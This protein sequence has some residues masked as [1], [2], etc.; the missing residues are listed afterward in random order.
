LNFFLWTFQPR[1]RPHHDIYQRGAAPFETAMGNLLVRHC[2]RGPETPTGIEPLYL[3]RMP[4]PTK[5]RME[6]HGAYSSGAPHGSSTP[7][8]PTIIIPVH[9]RKRPRVNLSFANNGNTIFVEKPTKVTNTA[10]M[11]G[12]MN[13]PNGAAAASQ[14]LLSIRR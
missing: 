11:A 4:I 14:H 9:P 2:A 5:L 10:P 1:Q 12:H 7:S 3:P 13:Y 8:S 6:Y